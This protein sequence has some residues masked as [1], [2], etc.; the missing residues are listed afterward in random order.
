MS[1]DE[2]VAR[3]AASQLKEAWGGRLPTWDEYRAAVKAGAVQANRTIALHAS[4]TAPVSIIARVLYGI[5]LPWLGFLVIP[6]CIVAAVLGWVSWW[7]LI[8]AAIAAYVLT[9]IARDGQCTC[10]IEGA[11]RDEWFY[12]LMAGRGALLFKPH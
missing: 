9:K 4:R 7:W 12:R 8:G 5:A 11:V 2:A 3:S 1:I 10:L 6:A